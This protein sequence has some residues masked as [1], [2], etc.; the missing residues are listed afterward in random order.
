[1]PRWVRS[2]LAGC[3]SCTAGAVP[4][5]QLD[6]SEICMRPDW[7]SDG[8]WADVALEATR[9][10]SE[11]RR[12]VQFTEQDDWRLSAVGQPDVETPFV[13]LGSDMVAQIEI[14]DEAVVVSRYLD[15]NLE[16]GFT[17]V[18]TPFELVP[19]A[20][21]EGDGAVYIDIDIERVPPDE[22]W[23]PGQIDWWGSCLDAGILTRPEPGR[24]TLRSIFADVTACQL[25]V[26]R[27]GRQPGPVSGGC[28]GARYWQ[29]RSVVVE[30]SALLQAG[31]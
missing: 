3:V 15:G 10:N 30:L 21:S 18:A 6:L 13:V 1:M 4:S 14:E 16:G 17:L 7:A 5:H 2:W 8:S 20:H 22:G 31:P 29:Q 25:V 24:L 28:S 11:Q 19:T 27:R 12:V 9:T 23:Q 26:E